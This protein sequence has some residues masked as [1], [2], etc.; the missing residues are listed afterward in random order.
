MRL[1]SYSQSALQSMRKITLANFPIKSFCPLF[2]CILSEESF[3]K[4]YKKCF[5]FYQKSSFSSQN[6]Q[7]FHCP[8]FL[9]PIDELPGE[10]G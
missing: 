9:Q 4:N 8:F 10:T 2:I 7:F 1:F 3:L 6:I 5:L